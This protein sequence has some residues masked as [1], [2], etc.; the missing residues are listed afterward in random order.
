MNKSEIL[1]FVAKAL[2]F[3]DNDTLRMKIVQEIAEIDGLKHA[4]FVYL[5]LHFLKG[6]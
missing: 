3:N 1:H 5:Q 6:G 4:K 2:L